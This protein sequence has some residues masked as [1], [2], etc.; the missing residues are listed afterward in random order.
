MMVV[1]RFWNAL[2]SICG[3][4]QHFSIRTII[5]VKS[6]CVL[7]YIIIIDGQ[8]SEGYMYIHVAESI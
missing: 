4:N 7:K 8:K 2:K 6:Y 3:T 1:I 5:D